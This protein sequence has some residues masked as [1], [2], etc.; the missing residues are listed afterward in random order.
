MELAVRPAIAASSDFLII[1]LVVEFVDG[2][3]GHGVAQLIL[4]AI[5]LY[6]NSMKV[7]QGY[8]RD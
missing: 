6:V 4:N 1:H 3:F 8:G 5:F 7:S 2:V